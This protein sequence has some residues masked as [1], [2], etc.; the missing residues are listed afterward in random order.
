M[1]RLNHGGVP[2]GIR[3]TYYRSVAELVTRLCDPTFAL[4]KLPVFSRCRSHSRRLGEQQ[5]AS[6]RAGRDSETNRRRER[7]REREGGGEGAYNPGPRCA[8][9]G[10]TIYPS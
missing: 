4:H 10:H 9:Q 3:W 8:Y 5:G 2:P 1:A 6:A 7:E